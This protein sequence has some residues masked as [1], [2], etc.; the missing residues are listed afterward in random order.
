MTSNGELLI[1]W[2]IVRT[3]SLW[4]SVVFEKEVIFHEFD[5]KTSELD[6][7]FSKSSIWK[8]T[9]FVSRMFFFH[10]SLAASTSS[11]FH[12][13]VILCICCDTP[14]EK[15]GLWQLPIVSSV[16][17][18]DRADWTACPSRVTSFFFSLLSRNFDDQFSSNF[19]RFVILYMLRYTK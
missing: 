18:Q 1:I 4:S 7:H 5:F 11:N 12:R 14:S 9:T 15:T 3:G 2:N 13:F 6:F 17:K 8:H 19:H 16:F 10:Y